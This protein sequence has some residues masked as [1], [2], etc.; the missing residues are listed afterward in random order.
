MQLDTELCNITMG[1]SFV[2]EYCTKIQTL[3]DLL[4]NLD[5]EVPEKNIVIYTINGLSSKFDYVEHDLPPKA[6]S[7][8][9]QH[10]IYVTS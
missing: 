7:I 3:A 5:V 10:S 1:S 6:S 4:E 8:V 9:F 2:I